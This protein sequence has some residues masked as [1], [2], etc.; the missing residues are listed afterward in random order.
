MIGESIL[1]DIVVTL[2]EGTTQNLSIDD[3]IPAGLHLDTGFNG[4]GYQ[5]ITTAASSAAL[6]ADF[7]GTVTVGTFS[8][9][10]AGTLGGDGVGGQW[11]FSVSRATADNNAGN[12]SF[13]IRVQLVASDVA[14][15]QAG[16]TLP[17]SGQLVFSD[18]DGDTPNGTAAVTRTV[19]E[20]GTAPS[21]VIREPTLQISQ[22]TATAPE[23]GVDQGDT[24]EYDI[25]LS[26]GASGTDF[27]AYDISFLDSLPG[28]L[29]NLALL[30]VTYQGGATNNGG[31]DFQLVNGQLSTASNA[32]IDIA[33]GG[34]ITI[35]VSGTVLAAAASEPSFNNTATVEWTS[36]N[37]SVGGSADPAGETH[38]RRWPAQ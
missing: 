1:Y 22:T 7:N 3:L 2:P 16:V 23:L 14:G 36:L 4:I 26:N 31:P 8:G 38:G 34:S 5:L 25:T 10:N 21:V 17:N 27:N 30:G 29:G 18:P 11:T 24:V 6:G 28:E 35:R 12:N 32:N 15:N 37:G 19:G 33:T 9:L 13:V 20:S